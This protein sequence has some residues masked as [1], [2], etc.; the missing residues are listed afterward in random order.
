[1]FMDSSSLEDH[2]LFT[3]GLSK[4]NEQL[5]MEL[6]NKIA[7]SNPEYDKLTFE[8]LDYRKYMSYDIEVSHSN[9]TKS[10]FSKVSKE[11]SG[12][13]TQVPFYIVIAASFQQLLSRNKRINSGCIV[14]FDEAFNNMDDT[15]IDAMMKYYSSLS[16]QLLIAIPPQRVVN[17]IDYVNTSLVIVK[18]DDYA[19]IESF[20]D[21]RLVLNK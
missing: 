2:K 8:F 16:I 3:E 14:L 6:F 11:K 5:L 20:K 4:R 7:S 1:M 19:I 9:G 15:R 21:S 12:G 18:E 17:I 10:L 13:E